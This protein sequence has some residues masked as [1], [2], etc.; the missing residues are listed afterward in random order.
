[1]SSNENQPNDI[2]QVTAF[3]D[4]VPKK[5]FLAVLKHFAH[6]I[7]RAYNEIYCID[8]SPGSISN[9]VAFGIGNNEVEVP[10][11]E[12]RAQIDKA[13]FKYLQEAPQDHA[14]VQNLLTA[15]NLRFPD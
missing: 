15:I 14:A 6:G 10:N 11:K 2:Q 8:R 9:G 5:D 13:C 1:M 4:T 7:S 12:L 3:F